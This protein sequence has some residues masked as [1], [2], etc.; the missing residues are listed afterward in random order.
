M[1]VDDSNPS[2]ETLDLA[3]PPTVRSPEEGNAPDDAVQDTSHNINLARSDSPSAA[4]PAPTPLSIALLQAELQAIPDDPP[5]MDVDPPAPTVNAEP[6]IPEPTA[7]A[8]P[9]TTENRINSLAIEHSGHDTLP[10]GPA[11]VSGPLTAPQR[12]TATPTPGTE[13]NAD[14]LSLNTDFRIMREPPTQVPQELADASHRRFGGN[15]VVMCGLE[16]KPFTSTH[17]IELSLSDPLFSNISKWV[18]RK[19]EPQ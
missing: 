7:H 17:H 19:V 9:K 16:G 18:N 13:N 3:Q 5:L 8:L 4:L 15:M 1:D 2:S 11:C 12:E 14:P 6:Q 10:S